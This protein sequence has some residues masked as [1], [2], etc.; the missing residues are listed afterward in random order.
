MKKRIIRHSKSFRLNPVFLVIFVNF[1]RSNENI[2]KELLNL[3]HVAQI[4]VY[5]FKQVM[6]NNG[7]IPEA[8][9][10]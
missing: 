4:S 6:Y 9:K 7:K 10:G 3:P 8:M 5:K 2:M 1:R